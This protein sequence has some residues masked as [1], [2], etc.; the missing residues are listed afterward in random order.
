MTHSQAEADAARN[1]VPLPVAGY[2]PQSSANTSRVTTLKELEERILRELD[3]LA[4]LGGEIDQ[5]WLAIGRT[6]L[7]QGFMAATLAVFQPTRI[8]L[9]EDNATKEN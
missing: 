7:Q 8:G 9:P 4:K 6:Y 3:S 2:R 5:R 1:H